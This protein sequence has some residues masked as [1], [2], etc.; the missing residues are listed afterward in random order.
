MNEF[1]TFALTRFTARHMMTVQSN[2]RGNLPP[3]AATL[4]NVLKSV[5]PGGTTSRAFSFLVLHT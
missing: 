4:N 5:T 1:V 2:A 3:I